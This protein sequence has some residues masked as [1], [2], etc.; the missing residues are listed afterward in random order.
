[1]GSSLSALTGIRSPAKTIVI[2]AS[3]QVIDRSYFGPMARPRSWSSPLE[4][5]TFERGSRLRDIEG[6]AFGGCTALRSISLPASV[7][8]IAPTAFI[9]CAQCH[10]EIDKGNLHFRAENGFL[11]FHRDLLVRYF[12]PGPEVTIPD[13]IQRITENCFSGCSAVVAVLFRPGSSLGLI[14]R[15]GFADCVNLQC[16][17]IPSGVASLGDRCFTGCRSLKT[18]SFAPDSRLT[19]IGSGAFQFC[20]ALVSVEFP[21]SVTIIGD[22]CFGG[23]SSLERVTLPVDSKLARI[24]RSAFLGCGVLRSLAL[25]SSVEVVA[26]CCFL[27]APALTVLT[28]ASPSRIRELGDWPRMWTG[29]HEIPD[30]VEVLAVGAERRTS[31]LTLLFGPDSQLRQLPMRFDST[32][33]SRAPF[34][35]RSCFLRVSSRSLKLLRSGLEFEMSDEGGGHMH[36]FSSS[37]F[38][39][40]Q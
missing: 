37:F 19:G 1:M 39:S 5:I 12:G 17:Q 3:V 40:G 9:D 34:V 31:T 30:S 15:W 13:E 18:V 14:K 32:R 10:I 27:G 6:G 21:S 2:H 33:E 4:T 36:R 29:S 23:C 7:E 24:G 8:F 20:T 26:P 35:R 38:N 22:N 16:V 28:F 25:P 11:T